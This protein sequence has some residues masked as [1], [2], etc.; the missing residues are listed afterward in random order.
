MTNDRTKLT[1]D[2]AQ[3]III[4]R[5]F[6]APPEIVFRAWSDPELVKRWWAPLALGVSMVSCQAD[7]R[8]GGR[9]RYV[10][11]NPDGGQVAFSGE[12]TEVAPSSRLAYY[13]VFEPMADAGV[14]NLVVTFAA[15][16]AQTLVVSRE[17]YPS[18]EVRDQVMASG[19]E[20]GLRNTMNQLDE[21][22]DTLAR[23]DVL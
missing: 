16:Q 22:V 13:Q 6:N 5:R 17:I 1:L 4:S 11:Q 23:A 14:A 12:Y 3:T 9:Y 20:A 7:V 21:L 18:A 10:L 19:M 15:E 8:V 2:G